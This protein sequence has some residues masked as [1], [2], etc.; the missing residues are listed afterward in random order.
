MKKII[1]T[2]LKI[3]LFLI[4][5]FSFTLKEFYVIKK[6]HKNNNRMESVEN[7]INK[8]DLKKVDNLMIVAHP[9]DDMIWGGGH[10]IEDNY[11][12]ICITC[13]T[14]K[15]R[16]KEFQNVMNE[17]NDKYIMLGYPDLTE[18]K[19][20]DWASSYS[21]IENDIEYIIKFKK[22][23][24]IVTHNPDGEYGHQHHKMT[25]RIVT[26]KSIKNN[27]EDSLYYFGK[28]YTK[29]EKEKLNY[30]IPEIDKDIFEEK[31]KV[32]KLYVSQKKVIDSFSHML[33]HEDFI[34]YHNWS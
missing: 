20:D 16:V 17:T 2:L 19:R 21:K 9:D 7:L 5:I 22:W 23:K 12:V 28:Y 29:N 6:E 30:T 8:I 13:G 33:P 27:I 3:L 15:K 14:V 24:M 31:K 18:G 4:F 34:S 10:L 11:L 25:N 1:V 32:L 26:D